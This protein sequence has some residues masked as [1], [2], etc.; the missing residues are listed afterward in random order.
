MAEA[1]F[2]KLEPEVFVQSAGTRLSGPSQSIESLSPGTDNVIKVMDEENIDIRKAMRK[3]IHPDMIKDTDMIILTIEETDPVPDY[4]KND[5]RVIIW[6]IEDP[7]GKNL[8]ETRKI[9]NQI[10]K[11][12]LNFIKKHHGKIREN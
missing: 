1:L 12:I 8:E 5:P 9:K 10:Y 4:L 11:K 7:K 3:Q 6:N 2:R